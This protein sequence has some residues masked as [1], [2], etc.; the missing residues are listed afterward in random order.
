MRYDDEI[1]ERVQSLNDIIEVISGYIPLK[2][3]GRN[4]K[5]L[6]PFHPE[7]T[8][9]FMV[10]ADKQIFHCFGC[11]TGGDVFS[12][13]MKYENLTFPEALKQLA[14]RVHVALPEPL[15][16]QG[17]DSISGRLYDVYEEAARYYR[18]NLED[19]E[20]GRPA[21]DY[22]EGR[23][24][25]PAGLGEFGI[26][27][28]LPDWRGLLEHLVRKG[29]KEDFL[30][31]AGLVL[32][33]PQ[34]GFYD[35]LRARVI[36]PIRNVQTKVVAFGGRALG[37]GEPKYI[38]SPE[39]EIFRKR[40][41][42]YGL[43]IAKRAV[44]PDVPRM[45]VVE[46]YLDQI[47]MY[48]AG[49]RNTVAT[50][51]TA[52]TEEHVRILKRYV[53]EAVLIYDGDRAGE[54]ASLRGLEVFLREGLLVRL[55]SLP[56]GTDPDAMLKVGGKEAFD[57]LISESR[58]IFD[59]KLSVLLRK[60]DRKDSLGLLK[61]TSEFLETFTQ[62]TN[63]VLLD[64]Y[65]NRL[66]GVLGVQADSIRRELAKLKRRFETGRDGGVKKVEGGFE[67]GSEG[68]AHERDEF[69]L[70]SLILADTSLLDRTVEVLEPEEF[71]DVTA[72]EIYRQVRK[73]YEEGEQVTLSALLRRLR[74]ETPKAVLAKISFFDLDETSRLKA[75][76]DCVTRIKR[77]NIQK[78][79]EALQQR[80]RRAESEGREEEVLQY[81]EEYRSLLTRMK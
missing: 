18:R 46:G 17:S 63:A 26:G 61:I 74:E 16:G 66:S 76:Q 43:H 3:A 64:Q 75:F 70:L 25:D 20:L 40:R 54:T 73:L 59:F 37:P 78:D 69:T 60:Y 68:G 9:S 53:G 58:D 81:I 1:V 24:F 71:Q 56:A 27:F 23:G 29:F 50:L 72:R 65:V 10:S 6:C 80:I 15:K 7:K 51:G 39:S 52:L 13:L 35:L 48:L 32:K 22:L 47:R 19:R 36:F 62:I 4:F 41:E 42:F 77:K 5:A 30:V 12:F 28:A 55:C 33:S 79:L 49:Y 21:R 8:P 44:S 2:R 57:K 67:P 31:R 45:Y 11:G 38:N 34:G 14:G